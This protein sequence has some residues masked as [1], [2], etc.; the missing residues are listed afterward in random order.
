MTGRDLGKNIIN[1]QNSIAKTLVAKHVWM[2]IE[3]K[4]CSVA[5]GH[6]V[7]GWSG[8]RGLSNVAGTLLFP[9]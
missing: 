8:Q 4:E 3:L 7:H 6:E 9:T 2:L 1:K 5:N